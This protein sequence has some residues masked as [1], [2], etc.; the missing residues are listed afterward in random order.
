MAWGAYLAL[1]ESE[2][3]G[4]ISIR[5]VLNE[6]L[7]HEGGHIGFAVRPA[8]R[9]RGYAT[10]I[11]QQGL[12]IARSLGIERVLVTCDFENIGSATVIQQCGGVFETVVDGRA[13]NRV[14][15]YWIRGGR[16]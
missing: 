6:F 5:H 7:A 8:Y 4:R 14:C 10:A 3:V 11:L 1:L 9:H 13:G 15:R 16:G 12:V 2:I